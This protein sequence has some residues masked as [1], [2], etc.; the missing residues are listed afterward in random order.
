MNLEI[1]LFKIEHNNIVPK[2]GRVLVSGPFLHDVYFS[3]S[4]ILL[5]EHNEKGTMGFV[6]NKPI[7]VKISDL[8]KDFPDFPAKISIGGPV[9]R[10][11]LQVLHKLGSLIPNS[12]HVFD[13]IFWGGDFD[14]LKSLISKNQILPDEI[15]FFLGYS[16]WAVDQ[17]ETEIKEDSWLVTEL[18]AKEVM[19]FNKKIWNKTLKKLDSKYKIWENFPE[20]PSYN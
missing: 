9:G 14:V 17:L 12:V 1:D 15:L 7:D 10:D 20:N 18:S 13:D 11:R 3:K 2:Q 5:T 16:G 4:V 6:L 8:I 19:S